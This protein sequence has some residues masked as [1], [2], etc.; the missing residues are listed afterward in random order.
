MYF[1]M[2]FT[3]YLRL[4]NK[5]YPSNKHRFRGVVAWFMLLQSDSGQATPVRISPRA[6]NLK[7]K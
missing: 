6:F 1:N 4:N 2:R 3:A 7:Q 5:F